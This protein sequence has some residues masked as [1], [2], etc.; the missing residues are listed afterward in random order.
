V[1]TSVAH[2]AGALGVPVWMLV[3]RFPDVRWMLARADSPWYD[4]L[5]I[6]RQ[7]VA[8]D[9]SELIRI[10]RQ[11]LDYKVQFKDKGL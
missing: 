3:S 5:Q 10:V 2:L 6:F 7:T 1:D 11:L 4:S 9:W 8:G